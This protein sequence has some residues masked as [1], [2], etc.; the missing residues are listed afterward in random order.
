VKSLSG[1]GDQLFKPSTM[2]H[3]IG[4]PVNNPIHLSVTPTCG[5]LGINSAASSRKRKGSETSLCLRKGTTFI[6]LPHLHITNRGETNK[7]KHLYPSYR[8][9]IAKKEEPICTCSAYN[10]VPYM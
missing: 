7:Y 4:T 5:V 9:H 1:F 10:Y 2:L 6:H 8:L 3:K